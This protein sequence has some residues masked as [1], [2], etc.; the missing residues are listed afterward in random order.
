MKN[1]INDLSQKTIIK[2][3]KKN[4]IVKV[5]N[6]DTLTAAIMLEYFYNKE[7]LIYHQNILNKNIKRFYIPKE[8][9]IN[10]N[11]IIKF[12]KPTLD[13]NSKNYEYYEIA[14]KKSDE[15]N[16]I[17]VYIEAMKIFLNKYSP[18][19][20]KNYINKTKK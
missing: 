10:K 16:L 6:L 4:N 19:L 17:R 1:K 8:I 13:I 11:Q 7:N 9:Y 18:K 12:S 14:V 5:K 2:N 15:N 20:A 3:S